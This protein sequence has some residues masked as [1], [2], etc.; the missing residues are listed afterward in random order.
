MEYVDKL[1]E[2][3]KHLCLLFKRKG[4]YKN[5]LNLLLERY[6]IRDLFLISIMCGNTKV[7]EKILPR[8]IENYNAER[9][10]YFEKEKLYRYDILISLE[11]A[12]KYNR[13]DLVEVLINSEDTELIEGEGWNSNKTLEYALDLAIEYKR[14]DIAV[15]MLEEILNRDETYGYDDL[16]VTIVIFNHLKKAIE[17]NLVELGKKLLREL[18]VQLSQYDEELLKD[19]YVKR[20]Q[21]L[22]E[23]YKPDKE[24]DTAL[25][26][27]IL[28]RLAYH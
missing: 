14:D 9:L 1:R 26:N 24:L 8:Y 28:D 13:L 11:T 7:V 15:Y 16:D 19:K 3:Y 27:A 23:K 5:A 22:L 21:E 25:R 20:L 4:Y 18:V 6:P 12:I 17:H 10:I 2:K